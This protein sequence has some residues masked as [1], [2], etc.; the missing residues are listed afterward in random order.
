MKREPAVWRAK[1]TRRRSRRSLELEAVEAPEATESQIMNIRSLTTLAALCPLATAQSDVWIEVRDIDLS[2]KTLIVYADITADVA[3]F[4]FDLSGVELTGASG[5][6]AEEAAFQ[7]SFSCDTEGC[8]VLSFGWGTQIDAGSSGALLQLN[9]DCPDGD[10]SNGVTIC[11]S[12]EVF[13]S[14]AALALQ[15]DT[16]P[17]AEGSIGS[18]FCSGDG[19]GSL[20][21]CGNPSTAGG[22][23]NATGGGGVLSVSGSASVAVDDLSFSTSGLI[24][25]QPVL[26]FAGNNAVN[27]GAG[28]AFG[29]G[30]RCAGGGVRRLGVRFSDAAG[31]ASWLGGLGAAGGWT[32]GDTRRFQGW[33]RDALGPCGSTFNLTQ[34]VELTL[35]A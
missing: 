9:F 27:E 26:L 13:S 4:Q 22:C 15:S 14:P 20:C 1:Y 30:L 33:Y 17:C 28:I 6:L 8:R 23:A 18:S 21:P 7:T 2:N 31:S 29:D 3:G 34:G 5:G 25:G 24:P 32:A 16:G 35:Q 11:L 10:C 12:D 19:S